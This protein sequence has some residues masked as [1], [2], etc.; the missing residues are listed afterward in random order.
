MYCDRYFYVYIMSNRSKT[1]YAGIT[2]NLVKRVFQ[3]KT[4]AFERIHIT[5]QG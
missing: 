4:H 3:H 5:L 1:L 2:S